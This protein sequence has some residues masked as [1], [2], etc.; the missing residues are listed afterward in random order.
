MRVDAILFGGRRASVVPLVVEARDWAHG[1]FLGA[2]VSS[3]TTAAAVG[4]AGRLRRDPVCH[5][6]VLRV[7]HGRLLGALAQLA[8]RVTHSRSG[9]RHSAER[10][11]AR[12]RHRKETLLTYPPAVSTLRKVEVHGHARAFRMLGNGPALLLLHGIGSDGTTWDA[13][14]PLLAERF[15]VVVPDLL[16][17][18]RSAKPR[19]DYS[20]GGYAN[21]MRDL[22]SIL[23]IEHVTVIG[24][25]FGGGVAMQF[26]YQYPERCERLVLV[27]SGG[28][29]PEVN[30]LLRVMSAPNADMVLPLLG[31][32]GARPITHLM[33]RFLRR[34]NT[35]IGVDADYMM[36]VF[37]ALPDITARRAF[38]R[39]LRS[40]IDWRGQAITMLDRCYLTQGMP[41][42]LIWG[43]RDAVIPPHHADIA[44]AAM[45]GSR[46]E[47]FEGAGHFPHQS[48]PSRFYQL[49]QDFFAQTQPA[50]YSSPEW[51][52]VLR[53]GPPDRKPAAL[54]H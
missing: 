3:E 44:H 43:T 39:T 41:T 34:L 14:A 13:V 4:A 54:A 2:T 23:D 52:E 5:V 25:S 11:G 18:G 28:V 12:S 19:A 31:V 30:P 16:G 9:R 26:A 51:R 6:A 17:H 48:D 50:S 10:G 32:A 7:R 22:L 15:T 35:D 24:H 49:L 46:L 29:C 53:R 8:G 47:L 45:P 40:V 27:S 21:G 42:L 36:R 37:D 1:V 20:I 33:F 38:V